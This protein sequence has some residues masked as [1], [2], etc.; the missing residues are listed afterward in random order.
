[1]T[2]RAR[3]DQM[4]QKYGSPVE[5]S[6]G[7]KTAAVNAVIQPLSYR[8]RDYPQCSERPEGIY[9]T[10]HFLYIGPLSCRIDRLLNPVVH[11]QQQDFFVRSTQIKEIAGEPLYI[12]AVLQRQ[13]VVPE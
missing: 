7:D 4:L 5:I 10:S 11:T 8:N 12:T 1:M 13:A 6:A 2:R 9:D 3:V